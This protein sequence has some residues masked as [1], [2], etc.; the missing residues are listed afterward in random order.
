MA[1][2]GVHG[3]GWCNVNSS[4]QLQL[5]VWRDEF[6]SCTGYSSWAAQHLV[7]KA[8]Q[9]S[10]TLGTNGPKTWHPI[11]EEMNFSVDN[12]QHSKTSTA[13]TQYSTSAF[14]FMVTDLLQ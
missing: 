3:S 4:R 8:P 7:M 10:E 13:S 14:R 12:F 9:S 2:A 11:S 6:F 5:D 1:S